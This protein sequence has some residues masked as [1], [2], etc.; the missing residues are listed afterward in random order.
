M[1]PFSSENVKRLNEYSEVQLN[2]ADFTS[3]L[4]EN[5]ADPH[6]TD[7]TV[8]AVRKIITVHCVKQTKY[9]NRFCGRNV[10]N[11]AVESRW[12][13]IVSTVN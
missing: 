5:T 10:G 4:T 13:D 12:Y 8:N 11:F 3:Y 2:Y 6:C 1:G 7:Q 9:L